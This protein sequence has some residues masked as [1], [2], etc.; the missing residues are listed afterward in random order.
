MTVKFKGKKEPCITYRVINS[1]PV[2][3]FDEVLNKYC[4]CIEIE[5]L[6]L[7]AKE[8]LEETLENK[9]NITATDVYLNIEK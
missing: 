8:V 6:G 5:S 4:E 7:V 2:I 1:N 9:D 3:E